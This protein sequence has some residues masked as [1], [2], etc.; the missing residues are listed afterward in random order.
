M[1]HALNLVFLAFVAALLA[2]GGGGSSAPAPTGRL[3]LRL[4][5]DSFPGYTQAIVS[6]EKVE[7]SGDGVHWTTLGNVRASYDLLALQSGHSAL[8]VTAAQ[9]TAGTYTQF[10]LTWATVNYL[11]GAMQPAYV[12]FPSSTRAV[13]TMPATTTLTGAI[14]VPADGTATAQLMF[15]GQQA[16][17]QRA[18]TGYAFQATGTVHDLSL[19]ARITGH[20][21]DS[22]GPLA[23]VEVFA[24]TVDG[25]ELA[26]LQRRAFTDG[27]GNYVLEGL[28]MGSVY[29]MTAQP[30]GTSGS[31]AAVAAAPINALTATS[32]TADLGFSS[33]LAPGTVTVSI[34]PASS[35]TQ[36]TWAE[37]RQT[38][39][40][41]ASGAKALIVRS[42]TVMTGVTQ[43]QA[44]ITGLAPGSYG[45]A[46]QRSSSGG[47]PIM[48]TGTQALVVSGASATTSLSFP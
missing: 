48:K 28:P 25:A 46:A 43:D 47:T 41:G 7:T 22:A 36:G 26:T 14:N 4:G 13:M 31:Y 17:Q 35:Q 23:G 33:A 1:R 6:L 19:S 5:S 39:A 9:V 27:S 10:R 18:A 30:A 40:T 45:V 21:A 42:Q 20:L 29:F 11:D 24:E 3:T 38:V 34:T 12:A 2:C 32:Y 37:L 44:G 15:S 8:L 16:V